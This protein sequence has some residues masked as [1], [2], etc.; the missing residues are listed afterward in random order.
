MAVWS[1][2][3]RSQIP[4]SQISADGLRLAAMELALPVT[5][6]RVIEDT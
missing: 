4:I 2:S 5:S 6:I 3:G 1:E